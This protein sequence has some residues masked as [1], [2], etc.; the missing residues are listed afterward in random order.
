MNAS[1]IARDLR[2][3][4]GDSLAIATDYVRGLD[5]SEARTLLI[6]MLA[7]EIDHRRREEQRAREVADA[8]ARLFPAAEQQSGLEHLDACAAIWDCERELQNTLSAHNGFKGDDPD[9]RERLSD[10]ELVGAMK[11]LEQMVARLDPRH[12]GLERGPYGRKNI[13]LE[14]TI[15]YKTSGCKIEHWSSKEVA[16]TRAE[17]LR[18]AEGFYKDDQEK[19]ALRES[20]GLPA[21]GTWMT[22]LQYIMDMRR[23]YELLATPALLDSPFAIGD[24]TVTTWGDASISQHRARYAWQLRDAAGSMADA[25][26][27]QAAI[28]LIEEAGAECLRDV[29]HRLVRQ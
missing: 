7:E 22:D 13:R 12:G 9:G 2:D 23:R 11:E 8:Y 27:H 10:D 6:E 28:L 14:E 15:W 29:G 1:D 5:A 26:R 19:V 16:A 4:A 17:A 18:R 20:V 24:G 21:F 3:L 25:E